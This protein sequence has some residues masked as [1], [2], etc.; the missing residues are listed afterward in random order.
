MKKM[1][2]AVFVVLLVHAAGCKAA[3][4]DSPSGVVSNFIQ[5]VSALA[6]NHIELADFP[7]YARNLNS[8]PSVEFKNQVTFGKNVTPILTK[9]RI[10]PSDCGANGIYLQFVLDDGTNVRQAPLDTVSHFPKL[11]LTLYADVVLSENAPP[12][13][14]KKLEDTIARHKAMLQELEKQQPANKV[15]DEAAGNTNPPVSD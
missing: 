5:E 12:E 7:T 4:P 9:R 8:Q 14:K 11:K 6:S 2:A 13:L 3:L 15:S 10:R 1:L